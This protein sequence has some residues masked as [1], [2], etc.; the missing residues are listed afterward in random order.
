VHVKPQQAGHTATTFP[1]RLATPFMN[2]FRRIQALITSGQLVATVVVSLALTVISWPVTDLVPKS[3]LDPSWEVGLAMA[4]LQRLHWG[5]SVDFTYGPL[6]FLTV[7]TLYFQ[8]TAALSVTFLLAS[9]ALLFALLLRVT[10]PKFPGLWPI[11]VAYVVGASAILLV[12]P[13]DLLLGCILLIGLLAVSSGK[14]RTVWLSTAALGA[15]AGAGLLL[16]F[17]VGLLSLWV[18]AVL[19][20]S[21]TRWR[22]ALGAVAVSLPASLLLIWVAT[23]N[24]VGN[25]FPYF[26]MSSAVAGGFAGAMSYETGRWHE[27]FYAAIVLTCLA[28]SL[29][30]GLRHET[31]RTQLATALIYLGFT[32]VALKEG[33]VR[34]DHHD[35]A[36]FGLMMIAFAGVPWGNLKGEWF[37]R[38]HRR[39][40]A[41]LGGT[42]LLVVVIGWK[43]ADTVAANPLEIGRDASGFVSEVRSTLRP[44]SIMDSARSALAAKYD[45][46]TSMLE[47]LRGQTVAIEPWE[48]TVAWVFGGFKWDPEP[49]L[50]QYSAYESSLDNLDGSF[51]RSASAPSRLLVQPTGDYRKVFSDPFFGAPSAMVARMCHYAQADFT[52]KW[53]LLVRVQDRCSQLILTKSLT[54]AFGQTVAVPR[55][56]P[57]DAV[58]ATFSGVGSSLAY[59]LEDFLLKAPAIE[60]QTQSAS[61]RFIAATSGD[62][63]VLRWPSTLGYS[64]PYTPPTISSFML[65]QNDLISQ[66]GHYR[67]T[68]YKLDVKQ[69]AA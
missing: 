7:P 32:W 63:H 8:S 57:G 28:G 15:L 24:P 44:D 59:R 60:M 20:I 43:A 18:A 27:W 22:S 11:L 45:I 62:L 4:F 29:W 35:L 56:P 42:L 19:V 54:V 69:D 1:Y 5:P 39:G 41:I 3:G 68:F 13:A 40:P 33:F 14:P 53:Q 26:R 66:S 61:Y 47:R 49:V 36:F 12:D 10:Q 64:A 50:Q 25:L 17:S 23:G 21:A 55:A 51:L 6:G 2:G 52:E 9:R 58:I 16:K 37:V 67:V 38:L 30:H 48:N 46:P 31:W 65:R 34:H